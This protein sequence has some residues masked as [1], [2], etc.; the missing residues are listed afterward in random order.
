MCT[1]V[2]MD[3]F[4]TLIIQTRGKD[5]I[6]I[7]I[8]V[9]DSSTPSEINKLDKIGRGGRGR[10]AG[11]R[12]A[13]NWNVKIRLVKSVANNTKLTARRLKIQVFDKTMN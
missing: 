2:F 9:F 11:R 3:L 12:P 8:V 6:K 1:C 7:S 5:L 4:K 10:G 13:E